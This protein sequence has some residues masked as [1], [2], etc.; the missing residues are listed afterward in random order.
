MRDP[1]AGAAQLVRVQAQ[2]VQGD[3]LRLLGRE[4]EALAVLL[5]TVDLVRSLRDADAEFLAL[6]AVAELLLARGDMRQSEVYRLQAVLA[7]TT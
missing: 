4:D 3:A 1:L 5:D 7:K 6:D 2:A